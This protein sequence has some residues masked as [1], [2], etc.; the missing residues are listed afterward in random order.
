MVAAGPTST[1]ASPTAGGPSTARSP[2]TTTRSPRSWQRAAIRW[3]RKSATTTSITTV[4]RTSIA[5]TASARVTRHAM[6]PFVRRRMLPAAPSMRTAAQGSVS[7]TGVVDNL[8]C[9]I[10]NTGSHRC[11]RHGNSSKP[12]VRTT[13]TSGPIVHGIT[14]LRRRL[15]DS[16][17]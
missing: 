7:E 8:I 11:R 10:G 17:R 3:R 13:I 1:N 5:K 15:S 9:G 14:R 6:S 2:F 4:T 16:I 12:G